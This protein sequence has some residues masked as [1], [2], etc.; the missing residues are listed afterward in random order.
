[1]MR[2]EH[3]NTIERILQETASITSV[4]EYLRNNELFKNSEPTDQYKYGYLYQIELEEWTKTTGIDANTLPTRYSREG[5]LPPAEDG[6]LWVDYDFEDDGNG[7]SYYE[8]EGTKYVYIALDNYT[9]QFD[10]DECVMAPAT[11]LTIGRA[12]SDVN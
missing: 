6:L 3:G 11:A 2:T 7:N 8:T 4:V 9:G 12:L 5:S 1:M 10:N